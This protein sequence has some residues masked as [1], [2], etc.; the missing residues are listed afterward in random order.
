[1]NALFDA[2]LLCVLTASSVLLFLP[3]FVRLIRFG[4]ASGLSATSLMFGMVNYLAWNVYLSGSRAWGLLAANVLGSVVWFAVAGMALRRLRPG[5]GGWL[6]LPWALLLARAIL[7]DRSA[8]GFLLALGTVLT[9]SPQAVGVWRAP[10]VS[11][12]SPATWSIAAVEGLSW[13]ASSLPGHLI[14]G[15][16]FGIVSTLTAASVLTAIA[17]RRGTGPASSPAMVGRPAR[18]GEPD[19]ANVLEPVP[20]TMS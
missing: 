1:M 15:I 10:S 9:Y 6:V 11:G 17:V 16:V 2:A 20:L 4:D 7:L 5:R 12:V 3:Q 14:G 18:V 19:R 8:L 13:F